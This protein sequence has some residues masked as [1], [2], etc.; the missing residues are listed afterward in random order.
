MTA[1]YS[2]NVQIEFGRLT[3]VVRW[4]EDNCE[5][6]WGYS[7]VEVPD[8]GGGYYRFR[9]DSEGQRAKRIE[10]GK[11]R[12]TTGTIMDISAFAAMAVMRFLCRL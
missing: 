6:G 3:D 11:M 9:F 1:N 7:V 10:I 8:A 12:N 2:A 4:C 5:K